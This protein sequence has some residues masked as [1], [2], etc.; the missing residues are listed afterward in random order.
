MMTVRGRALSVLNH[1][2]P[3]VVPWLGDLA[4]WVTWL[5]GADLM[6]DRYKGEGLYQL[7]RDLGVGFY[8]QGYFPFKEIHDGVEV[9]DERANGRQVTRVRTPY[10]DIQETH[11]YLP[12]SY[13]SART[14]HFIKSWRD[15]A[16]LRYLYE[17]TFYEPNYD[18]AARRYDLVGDNGLVLCYLP[19]SPFMELVALKAGIEAVTYALTDARAEF[20]ETL[21]V[22]TRKHDEAAEIALASPAECLMIPENLSSESV[23]K[24]L[25]TRYVRPYEAR[26]I[27]R[28]RAVGKY[29][30]IHIDGTLRGLMREVSQTGFTVLEAVTP[31]PSGDIPVEELWK[32]AE[33]NTII[34][35][36]LPGLMFSDLVS[37]AEFDV[38]V[39]R[40]LDVFKTEPRYVLGV[41]DQVPPLARW[42]RIA[43][44]RELV[45]K[46]GYYAATA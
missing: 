19:K 20:E 40:V 23:G 4:Y 10:G 35:G 1:R 15:L 37:D 45:E 34:W 11:E 18:L 41:A 13:T 6:P 38:F 24:R 44:V 46:H 22:M 2:A 8:L 5:N 30:Y 7:H 28:I 12:D 42:E 36:G 3:D 27:E 39:I 26:W 21:A 9:L 43:R 25:Y 29:S 32:W 17:H 33:P 14:E 16:P 31:E